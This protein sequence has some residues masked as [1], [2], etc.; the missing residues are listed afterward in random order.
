MGNSVRLYPSYGYGPTQGRTPSG[1]PVLGW[2]R[3]GG[4]TR[5][6]RIRDQDKQAAHTGPPISI[7]LSEG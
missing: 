1:A 7:G 3:Q 5:M 6:L 4:K 2:Q